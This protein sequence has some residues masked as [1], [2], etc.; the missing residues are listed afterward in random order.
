MSG[1]EAVIGYRFRHMNNGLRVQRD[2]TGT[3][4]IAD[5][6]TEPFATAGRR[7]DKGPADLQPINLVSDAGERAGGEDDAL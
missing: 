6:F 5:L 4:E 2:R 1:F 7:H 3:E